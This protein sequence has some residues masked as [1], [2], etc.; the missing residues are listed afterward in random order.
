MLAGGSTWM[1]WILKFSYM[2]ARV[3]T[4]ITNAVCMISMSVSDTVD[5]LSSVR[6]KIH[7]DDHDGNCTPLVLDVNLNG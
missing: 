4:Q 2:S 6:G 1:S 5:R 3:T 7:I